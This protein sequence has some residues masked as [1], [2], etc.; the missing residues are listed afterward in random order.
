MKVYKI[1]FFSLFLFFGSYS[2]AK[3]INYP[4]QISRKHHPEIFQLQK[5]SGLLIKNTQYLKR[6]I[7][8][9][10]RDLERYQKLLSGSERSVIHEIIIRAEQLK[11]VNDKSERLEVV[12]QIMELA[13]AY[14]NNDNKTFLLKKR[15]ASGNIAYR[16]PFFH[17][18]AH[19]FFKNISFYRVSHKTN[20]KVYAANLADG[21]DNLIPFKQVEKMDNLDV[22]DPKTSAFWNQ[23]KLRNYETYTYNQEKLYKRFCTNA[24]PLHFRKMKKLPEEG[25]GYNPGVKVYGVDEKGKK[26]RFSLKFD[27][28]RH[29]NSTIDPFFIGLESYIVSSA[30]ALYKAL[31]YNVDKSFYCRNIK[32]VYKKELLSLRKSKLV[33]AELWSPEIQFKEFELKNGNR[34]PFLDAVNRNAYVDFSNVTE[35]EPWADQVFVY[36]VKPE[37]EEQIAYVIPYGASLQYRPKKTERVSLWRRWG[38]SHEDRR[39]LRGLVMIDSWI[40]NDDNDG[41]N[42][43]LLIKK[44]K[45]KT[46][47][48]KMTFTVVDVGGSFRQ[49]YKDVND[50]EYGSYPPEV[51]EAMISKDTALLDKLLIPYRKQSELELFVNS[52]GWDILKEKIRGKDYPNWKWFTPDQ[53]LKKA[54]S[55]LAIFEKTQVGTSMRTILTYTTW[56]DLLWGV[57][58]IASLSERQISNALSMSGLGWSGSKFLTEKLILRRDQLVQYFGLTKEF[59]LL[60]PNGVDRYLSIWGEGTIEVIGKKGFK[61]NVKVPDYGYYVD[62]GY[63]YADRS[64]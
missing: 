28:V 56:D 11:V 51:R 21:N 5:Y 18:I 23:I 13:T 7:Q 52:F 58:K 40:G 62:D 6:F 22:M 27:N 39:E 59:S 36:T 32:L 8:V 63:F 30:N 57:R 60:R 38:V 1:I 61:S 2:W 64:K 50:P 14:F 15:A 12:N 54:L 46:K 42:L 49:S 44:N 26:K 3:K 45:D 35:V 48:S 29:R 41:A 37:Y 25:G 34:I 53:S 55:E 9:G 31:G 20:H 10:K 47:P 43:K 17:F 4:A 19:P 24:S 33:S 16:H